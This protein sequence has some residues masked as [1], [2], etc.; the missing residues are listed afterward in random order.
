MNHHP[1]DDSANVSP[2][3][4]SVVAGCSVR[5]QPIHSVGES[6]PDLAA[7]AAATAPAGP[8]AAYQLEPTLQKALNSLDIKL[9]D[10]LNR[11]RSQ[12]E[13]VESMP[14]PSPQI[15]S[16]SVNAANWEHQSDEFDADAEVFTAEIVPPIGSE[17]PPAKAPGG[18]I[19]IDGLTTSSSSSQS[20]IAHINYAPIAL[21]RSATQSS[22]MELNFS[23]GGEI[24]P[25]RHDEYSS[26]SQELL[27][28]I[29]F[30]YPA[31]DAASNAKPAP[32]K[33]GKKL[34]TP[35]KIGSL[36]AACLIAG[37]G[38]YAYF[39]PS[40]L[41]PLV[42]T[43]VA[44]P[45]ASG[46]TIQSP[47]LAANEFSELNLSAINSIKLPATATI[48]TTPTTITGITATGGTGIAPAAIPFNGKTQIVPPSA[49]TAQP[50]LADSLV[51]S[52]LPSNFQSFVKPTGYQAVPP[53]LSR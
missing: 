32:A 1:S 13:G 48:S 19:I 12:H 5:E 2:S 52:L 39:N 50:R 53:Q 7:T 27:R 43:K 4:R 28:Q 22:E 42:A 18:F 46:Q 11:F 44:S 6:L 20:A 33:A 8:P 10:E 47:N 25:F 41:A 31:A 38:A 14:Q 51:K 16:R 21:H 49:I 3:D 36:A 15:E 29:Q 34:F 35:L 45:A 40:V 26:S 24:A 23:S 17:S 37:G 9:E 30:G